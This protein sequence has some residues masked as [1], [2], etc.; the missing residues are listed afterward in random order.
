[1]LCEFHKYLDISAVSLEFLLL[2]ECFLSV[3][4]SVRGAV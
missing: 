1:M 4:G 3:L 2:E